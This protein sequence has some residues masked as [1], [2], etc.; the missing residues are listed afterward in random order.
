MKLNQKQE[1]ELKKHGYK[2][3]ICHLHLYADDFRKSHVWDAVVRSTVGGDP[4]DFSRI[5]IAICGTK[6]VW[7]KGE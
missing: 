7:A 6:V 2:P 4:I 1:K 3:N 5:T